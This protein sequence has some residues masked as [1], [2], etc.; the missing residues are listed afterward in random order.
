MVQVMWLIKPLNIQKII[1]NMTNTDAFLEVRKKYEANQLPFPPVPSELIKNVMK[2]N[3]WIYS[4]R[5]NAPSPYMTSIYIDELQS[6]DRMDY[7]LLGHAG[8]GIMSYA[9]HFYLVKGSLALFLQHSWGNADSNPEEDIESI[10]QDYQ[11][12]AQ[13][14]KTVENL[15]TLKLPT[16]LVIYQSN[17]MMKSKWALS[18]PGDSEFQWNITKPGQVMETVLN[19]LKYL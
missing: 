1:F 10:R 4:T 12:A 8:H 5:A 17:L 7:I 3:D 19:Y 18:D 2:I 9:L 6:G 16:Q 15:E 13:L 11:L 14:I